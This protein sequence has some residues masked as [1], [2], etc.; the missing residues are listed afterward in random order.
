MRKMVTY[1]Q[2]PYLAPVI[3]DSVSWWLAWHECSGR[4]IAV[5]VVVQMRHVEVDPL[6]LRRHALFGGDHSDAVD[7][8]L[9]CLLFGAHLGCVRP[10]AVCKMRALVRHSRHMRVPRHSQL[11]IA[12][13]HVVGFA[14]CHLDDV[15]VCKLDECKAVHVST[16]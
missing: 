13:Y 12:H 3:D 5:D 10:R 14:H 2:L 9:R 11:M 4:N 6:M 16:P 8:C 1:M 15:F 7:L